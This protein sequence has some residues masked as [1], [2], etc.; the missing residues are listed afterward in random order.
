MS[1]EIQK[2]EALRKEIVQQEVEYLQQDG[3]ILNEHGAYCYQSADGNHLINLDA[4][5]N[6]YKEWLIEK[7][8]VTEK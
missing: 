8:Y 7:G 1:N 2:F 5:L 6:S 3:A 4:Y